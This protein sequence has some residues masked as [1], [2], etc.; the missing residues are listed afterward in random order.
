MQTH[1]ADDEVHRLFSDLREHMVGFRASFR[2]KLADRLNET[3]EAAE[4]PP[5]FEGL[6]LSSFVQAT[7]IV[8]SLLGSSSQPR[9]RAPEAKEDDE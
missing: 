2:D 5:P 7:N 3:S 8:F 1:D 6:I 4:R 9:A